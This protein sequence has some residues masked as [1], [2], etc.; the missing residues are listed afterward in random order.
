[1][2]RRPRVLLV[3]L[4]ALLW[5]TPVPADASTQTIVAGPGS[6]RGFYAIPA[7]VTAPDGELAFWNLDV[8]RH[9]VVAKDAHGPDDQPWCAE[10]PEGACPLFRS[11]T[12]AFDERAPVL[13]LENTEPGNAYVF[14]CTLHPLMTGVLAVGHPQ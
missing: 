2:R 11:A 12:I 1:M 7:A 5:S 13:G 10:H 8:V 6:F 14:F 3:T 9:N 4:I